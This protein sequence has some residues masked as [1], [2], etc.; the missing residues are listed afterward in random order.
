MA[1]RMI[2]PKHTKINDRADGGTSRRFDVRNPECVEH[3]QSC[4]VPACCGAE[5]ENDVALF[6]RKSG[7]Q[8]RSTFFEAEVM[9]RVL[10]EITKAALAGKP[11]LLLPRSKPTHILGFA[12]RQEPNLRS[13][14]PAMKR[15]TKLA[16]G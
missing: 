11:C 5:T 7:T 3:T 2:L 1:L 14:S 15:G 4:M 6:R 8:F 13:N 12:S 9:V 16:M 10:T